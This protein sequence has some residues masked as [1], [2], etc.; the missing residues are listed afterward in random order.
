MAV[1]TVTDVFGFLLFL[2]IASAAISLIIQATPRCYAGCNQAPPDPAGHATQP[3]ADELGQGIG[4]RHFQPGERL[5]HGG[6]IEKAEPF[7]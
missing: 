7:Q 2:G 5:L 3:V 1:T 6:I 4:Q